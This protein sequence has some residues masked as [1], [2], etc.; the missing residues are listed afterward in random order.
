[1]RTPQSVSSIEVVAQLQLSVASPG[2]LV[3]EM[4]FTYI[5]IIY[6]T[7]LGCFK[8]RLADSQSIMGLEHELNLSRVRASLFELVPVFDFAPET[9]FDLSGGIGIR[10]FFD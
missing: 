5:W 2:H 3:T 4:R 10:Y 9:E 6:S 1:M 8:W 7:I